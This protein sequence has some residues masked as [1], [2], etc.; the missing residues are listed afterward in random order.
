M[1][2][3]DPTLPETER[4]ILRWFNIAAFSRATVTYGNSP[5]NPVVGPGRKN[6]DMSLA[7]SFG[8]A[9][10]TALQFRVEAF[11]A[12][13]RVN[14]GNPNGT[15][16]NSN[17]GDH[18]QRRGRSRDAAVAQVHVLSRADPPGVP[19]IGRPDL[20]QGRRTA[21]SVK[22]TARAL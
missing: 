14:W 12:F 22:C 21:S 1:S 19:S 7:K 15:L 8:M 5:R 20:T 16:G 9:G 10:A 18:Q 11:N 4:T 2:G 13:N 6:V 17:F 3:Q